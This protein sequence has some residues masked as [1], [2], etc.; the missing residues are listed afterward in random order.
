MTKADTYTFT[1]VI[2][3]TDSNVYPHI[4]YLDSGCV[5]FIKSNQLERIMVNFNDGEDQHMGYM[6]A[7]DDRY[8]FIFNKE[9]MKKLKAKVGDHIEIKVREDSSKYGM[10]I[11]E[12]LESTLET[13]GLF[14][15]YFEKLTPGK[16]R[17]LIY[18]VNKYKSSD[19][20]IEKSIV[21]SEH[22]KANLGKIDYKQLNLAFR[23]Y[24][25]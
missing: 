25:S 22:L 17:S 9:L 3:K 15:N 2:E 4:I 24:N 11:S 6:P 7:G 21:I 19:K 14:R 16:Q 23:N 1:G 13:D 8:F 5:R 18:I 12:E 20:R 10:P